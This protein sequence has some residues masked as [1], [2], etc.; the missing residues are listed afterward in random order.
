MAF[1][2]RRCRHI[3]AFPGWLSGLGS[4]LLPILVICFSCRFASAA[5]SQQLYLEALLDFERYA[6]T[7]WHP[8]TYS[9]APS[10]SGYWGDGGSS[11]NGGI[12]GNSG[13]A[14]A[15][16]T[17]VLAQPGNPRNATRLGRI[18]QALNYD[19]ATHVTGSY[20]CVDGHQWVEEVCE[21]DAVA[22]WLRTRPA[23]EC[24]WPHRIRTWATT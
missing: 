19:T 22:R 15:Y 20:D 8:V 12:R 11:G 24:F 4:A 3:P 2:K 7:I 23:R 13:I 16:A 10:D 14:V 1:R 18:R 6:E 5:D 9:G 21:T 17:L